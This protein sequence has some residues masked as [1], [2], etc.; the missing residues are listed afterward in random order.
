M[1]L[2]EEVTRALSAPGDVTST[3]RLGAGCVVPGLAQAVVLVVRKGVEDHLEVVHTDPDQETRIAARLKILLPALRNAVTRE[4]QNGREFRWIP[5]VNEASTRFLK[6][7]PE[8]LKLLHD[9]DVGSLL[10]V[11]L[12]SGGQLFGAM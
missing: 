5:M 7:E 4:R 2:L 8:L 6:R 10:L 11:P 12:R 9:F 3:M 1:Q